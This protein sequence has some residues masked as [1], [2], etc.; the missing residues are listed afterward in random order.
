MRWSNTGFAALS[1]TLIL[2]IIHWKWEKWT[3]RLLGAERITGS[4]QKRWIACVTDIQM[5]VLR[6]PYKKC[7]IREKDIIWHERL[8][9][10]WSL[11]GVWVVWPNGETSV[12]VSERR[13]GGFFHLTW[14][15]PFRALA[16]KSSLGFAHF[17]FLSL[18]FCSG[19]K[20]FPPKWLY[21]SHMRFIPSR[22]LTKIQSAFL[23][24][25]SLFIFDDLVDVILKSL[26]I[27]HPIYVYY[28][29]T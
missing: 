26:G 12:Q 25:I 7:P 11:S 22:Q 4:H 19:G 23:A 29:Y 18:L 2:G 28:M 15:L 8:I 6:R 10:L 16:F 21:S 13:V 17:L 27:Y 3:T 9:S 24:V 14:A 20:Y 1:S 5:D